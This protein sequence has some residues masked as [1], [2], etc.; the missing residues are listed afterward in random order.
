[1]RSEALS[2]RARYYA[3]AVLFQR[4]EFDAALT[5]ARRAVEADGSNPAAHN[6]CRRQP[7][8]GPDG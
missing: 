2:V 6:E 5:L 3:A 7:R 4:G 8:D 1:M